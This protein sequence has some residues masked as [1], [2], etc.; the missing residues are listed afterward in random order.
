MAMVKVRGSRVQHV[1]APNLNF[2]TV[3]P[4]KPRRG[5]YDESQQ[6]TAASVDAINH[7]RR[8]EDIFTMSDDEDGPPMLVS[9]ENV[10]DADASLNAEMADAQ[11][12]KVPISIITGELVYHSAFG[13]LQLSLWCDIASRILMLQA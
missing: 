3:P 9:S 6:F 8:S 5:T 4:P 1:Q 12:K 2:R 10:D 11:I 13:L 7:T